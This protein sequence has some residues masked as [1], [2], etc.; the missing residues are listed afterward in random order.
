MQ[1]FWPLVPPLRYY[2]NLL[3]LYAP[4]RYSPLF[5]LFIRPLRCETFGGIGNTVYGVLAKNT[6][7]TAYRIP[8]LTPPVREALYA[9]L[10]RL[11]D[12]PQ[13]MGIVPADLIKFVF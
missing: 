1:E 10:Q 3:Q 2:N 9:E 5:G 11:P 13:V 12:L 7:Y 8:V 4:N 6:P